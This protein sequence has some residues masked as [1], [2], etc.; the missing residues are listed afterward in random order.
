MKKFGLGDHAVGS[1]MALGSTDSLGIQ[2]VG[3]AQ[4][5]KYS[6]VKDVVPP[7]FFRPYAQ[8][9]TVGALQFYVRSA[10]STA[11]TARAIRAKVGAIDPNLPVEELKTMPQQVK[12]NVMMDRLITT[13]A[14]AF[15][16]LATLLAAIG[17]YG[18]LAFTVARRTR[19]FGL[20]MAIGA[21]GARVRRLVLRQVAW[22]V[23]IGGVLGAAAA[24]VIG[25]L[26]RVPALPAARPRPPRVRRR[27]GDPRRRRVRRRPRARRPRLARAPDAGPALRVAAHGGG[28]RRQPAQLVLRRFPSAA[29]SNLHDRVPG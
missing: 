7:L 1:F 18:V 9:T 20:R 8:D 3:V 5:A 2:I 26:R 11:E 17:L 22:M 27:R 6:N 10:L 24:L 28:P 21:D 29:F 19:E 4:N 23:G 15:A 25:K 14:A 16:V 12:D 13:L